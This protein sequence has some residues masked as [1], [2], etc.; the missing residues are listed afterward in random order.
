M[1]PRRRFSPILARALTA[2][3]LLFS[4]AVPFILAAN[5]L[6][7][8]VALPS[9]TYLTGWAFSALRKLWPLLLLLDAAL[10]VSIYW[11]LARLDASSAAPDRPGRLSR[12][13]DHVLRAARPLVWLPLLAISRELLSAWLGPWVSALILPLGA[14]ALFAIILDRLMGSDV[15]RRPASDASEAA[16]SHGW[17]PTLAFFI[18]FTVLF[19]VFQQLISPQFSGGGDVKHYRIQ[20]DNLLENGNLELSERL[21]A[22][23]AKRHYTPEQYEGHYGLSHVRKNAAGKVYS[24]HSFGFPL[25]AAA[26]NLV[27]PA[28]LASPVLYYLIALMAVVA[29]R[30]SCRVVGAPG[31][32][33][34]VV[35]FLFAFSSVTLLHAISFLPEMLGTALTAAAFWAVV[36]QRAPRRRL[37]AT[38]VSLLSIA[39]LP[40]A[41][42]R[43]LP[44]AL[45]L[46]GFFGVEALFFLPD[47]PFW[48][49]KTPR[50]AAYALLFALALAAQYVVHARMFSGTSSYDFDNILGRA[51]WVMA[52][53]LADVRGT[54]GLFPLFLPLLAAAM[55][56]L[57]RRDPVA[58]WAFYSLATTAAVFYTCC[59]TDAALAGA[60]LRGR[61]L[62]QT[63]P[64]L[65][66]F[67]AVLLPRWA[68]SGRRWFYFLAAHSVLHLFCVAPGVSG[69]MLLRMPEWGSLHPLILNYWLPFVNFTTCPPEFRLPGALFP[70]ALFLISILLFMGGRPRLR[71]LLAVLLVLLAFACGWRADA[72]H[73]A[74]TI[75]RDQFFFGHHWK[76]F[77]ATP[78][79]ASDY[80][81]ALVPPDA[82]GADKDD[83]TPV[84]LTDDDAETADPL[85]PGDVHPVV[86]TPSLLRNHKSPYSPDA[87]H[88]TAL[89]RLKI[90]PVKRGG[91]AFRLTG[92]VERGAIILTGGV[93]GQMLTP[94]IRLEPGP[95]DLVIV[96]P[97]R[98][99]SPRPINL[100]ARLAD[101]DFG[102]ATFATL[103]MAP[104]LSG[105]AAV[106]PPFPPVPVIFSRP[107]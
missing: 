35:T 70:A 69:I 106:L 48:R 93:L 6:A 11:L 59:T 5:P 81:S 42:T 32:A 10:S 86:V 98:T 16:P 17:G 67:A 8:T 51:P 82:P 77:S 53:M 7:W 104:Y 101:P 3:V 62:F 73:R 45:M 78:S 37:A 50:L 66:P 28:N 105:A 80:F 43:F 13:A 49:R 89:S 84:I 68:A 95:F 30:A 55:I 57:F 72:L 33:A 102:H 15:A 58:R 23:L 25:L 96:V 4:L 2:A 79:A 20:T 63:V 65:L 60:C 99:G 34:N 36:A 18:V 100:F 9:G 24:Y 107:F 1:M 76:D 31:R 46:W 29:V 91:M 97:V 74:R 94:Y 90:H 26:A 54:V 21:H 44:L 71:Q 56:A 27:L 64:L 92:T 103:D 38:V 52:A 85:L 19:V 88:W 61:Y 87:D 83:F 47:E 41:H 40:L 39:Y 12:L 14:C 75:E 22:R